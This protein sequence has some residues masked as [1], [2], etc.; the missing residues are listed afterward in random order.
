MPCEKLRFHKGTEKVRSTKVGLTFSVKKWYNRNR[1]GGKDML[2]DNSQMVLE[3]S[4]YQGLYE[5]IIPRDHILRRLKDSIDFSF[6]NP[7]M[8]KQ[9]RKRAYSR[10]FA[11]R[12]Q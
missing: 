12:K 1:K 9:Y 3:L 7:M 4:P 6:V 5:E 2:K 11:Y 10:L 8:R